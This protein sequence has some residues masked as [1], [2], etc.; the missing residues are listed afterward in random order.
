LCFT[1]VGCKAIGT[2]NNALHQATIRGDGAMIE[3]LLRARAAAGPPNPAAALHVDS[4]GRGGW[5]PLGLAARAG[6]EKAV[7]AL[8]A[9][10][11]DAA[12]V[13]ENGKTPLDI[14]RTNKRAAIVQLLTPK[15]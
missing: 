7:R 13:M 1:P 12:V 10:G 2:A 9:G 3:L 15:E 8:L 5:T 6:D 14:A 11:A 4:A